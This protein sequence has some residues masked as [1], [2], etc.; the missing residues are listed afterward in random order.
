MP[1]VLQLVCAGLQIQRSGF[2]EVGTPADLCSNLA[3]NGFSD[4]FLPSRSE[5]NL[6]YVS[7]DIIDLVPVENDGNTFSYGIYYWSSTD[8]GEE[9]F[10]AWAQEFT[11]GTFSLLNR[12]TAS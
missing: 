10:N 9:Q 2:N 3:L 8:Y 6:L 11:S 12:N 1:D 4:W 5:L 7:K